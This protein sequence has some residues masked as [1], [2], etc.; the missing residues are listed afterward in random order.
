[1]WGLY[2]ATT[3]FAP[4]QAQDQSFNWVY[5]PLLI[6]LI[7]IELAVSS[8]R[9]HDIGKSG[10][11]QLLGLIPFIGKIWVGIELGFFQGHYRPNEYGYPDVFGQEAMYLRGNE[12]RDSIPRQHYR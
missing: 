2:A 4:E 5:L 7:W 8:K 6:P 10:W 12:D 1:M 9:Y 11:R 3:L